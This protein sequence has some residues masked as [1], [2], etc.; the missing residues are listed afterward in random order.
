MTK[1]AVFTRYGERA[2]SSRQ[3]F[4]LFQP[5]LETAGFDLQY[6]PFFDDET[7]L[8]RIEQKAVPFS[9]LVAAYLRR[10]REA[11]LAKKFDL[12]WVYMEML[13]FFPGFFET[14][15]GP[16]GMP[17]VIDMDD[18]IFHHYDSHPSALVRR[19]LGRKFEVIFR[20][21]QL[22]SVGNPYLAAYAR[23][24]CS[25][26]EIIPTVV[27]GDVYKIA[28]SRQITKPT[29]GWIGSPSTWNYV[30]P[31]LP[32]ILFVC[33]NHGATLTAIG[34]G[35]SDSSI[36]QIQH[37]PWQEMTEVQELQAMTVGIMPVDDNPF[38]RGKCGY[39][40]IQ[41]MACGLPVVASPVGVNTE[42]VD[43]GISGFLAETPE[44]WRKY[45]GL[46]LSNPQHARKMGE[47]G[48]RKFEARYSLQ[49]VG[50]RFVRR[51]SELRSDAEQRKL[52]GTMIIP[53]NRVD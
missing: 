16:R 4:R 52:G 27:D 7:T 47:A 1:V 24:F 23:Q 46:I 36:Q 12:C 10:I 20:Q 29:I 32:D 35:K 11:R 43:H 44:D 21:A 45:L 13:P 19:A 30:C 22:A 28:T 3:R 51:L 31:I 42:I 48:R 33:S 26:V 6:F 17:T 53:T 50:P 41:Y 25:N 5:L 40:L 2:A 37:R 38:A 9:S 34:A 39:K 18:A 8:S 14:L 15:L 49:V